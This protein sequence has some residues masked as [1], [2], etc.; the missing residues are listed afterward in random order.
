MKA[1]Q[2][3]KKLVWFFGPPARKVHRRSG[4]IHACMPLHCCM[5]AWF[6]VCIR[7][8][9]GFRGPAFVF[10]LV[11]R[12]F[13]CTPCANVCVN[14]VHRA[15]QLCCLSVENP[16]KPPVPYRDNF[17]G[18]EHGLVVGLAA[19][20]RP[21]DTRT[22]CCCLSVLAGCLLRLLVLF[23]TGNSNYLVEQG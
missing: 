8:G 10:G 3:S 1:W 2:L 14:P 18:F 5:F 11:L 22:H 9:T 16:A 20:V 6:G 4:Q 7:F 19:Y 21:C 15:V 23:K 13:D 17:C 12:L